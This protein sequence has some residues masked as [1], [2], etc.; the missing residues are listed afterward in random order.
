MKIMF[1]SDPFDFFGPFTSR[2]SPRVFI[3]SDSDYKK[4]QQEQVEAEIL[5]LESKA[6]R[7]RTALTEVESEI[8]KKQETYGLLPAETKQEK[9][10]TTE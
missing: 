5:V 7:L 8:N 9:A 10:V 2:Q 6:N 3:V 1:Y 4:Y